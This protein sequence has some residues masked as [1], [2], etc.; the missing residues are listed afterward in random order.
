[1]A[2][3]PNI[4]Q[5]LRNRAHMLGRMFLPI[6]AVTLLCPTG[7]ICADMAGAPPSAH[8]SLDIAA[9]VHGALL[10]EHSAPPHEQG[11]PADEHNAP[12]G[13]SGDDCPFCPAHA[14]SMSAAPAN[15]DIPGHD[16]PPSKLLHPDTVLPA[17]PSSF[18]PAIPHPSP[19]R[20]EYSTGSGPPAVPLNLL[21]CV[22]LN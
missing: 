22:F 11:A 18:A 14:A 10:H 12:S 19:P 9:H 15:C 1:M 13:E 4:L 2:S 20:T 16:A 21:H 3:R 5:T 6:V 8:G 7:A 17:P